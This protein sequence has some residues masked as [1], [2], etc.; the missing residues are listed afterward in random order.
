M[1]DGA[2]TLMSKL[3]CLIRIGGAYFIHEGVRTL[4]ISKPI[5][6]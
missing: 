3:A 2:R 4:V 6:A 5:D 1:E